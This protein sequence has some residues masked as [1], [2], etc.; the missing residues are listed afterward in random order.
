[1]HE[2]RAVNI[3]IGCTLHCTEWFC[4]MRILICCHFGKVF[5]FQNRYYVQDRGGA[6]VLTEK[7]FGLSG[8]VVAEW[9]LSSVTT[10]L[11]TRSLVLSQY[12][13]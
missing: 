4:Q 3:P 2:Y 11:Q 6:E 10:R 9:I 8:S 1:M 7:L 12:C 13:Q 5:M